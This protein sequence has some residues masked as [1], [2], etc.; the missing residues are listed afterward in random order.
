[1]M[2]MLTLEFQKNLWDANAGDGRFE[3]PFID[4]QNGVRV[5][6]RACIDYV[7]VYQQQ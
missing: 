5:M 4:D 6:S 1:M 3:G 2:M 7:R